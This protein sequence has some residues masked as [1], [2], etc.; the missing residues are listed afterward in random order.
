MKRRLLF[1]SAAAAAAVNGTAII[2][3]DQSRAAV[4]APSPTLRGAVH[5]SRAS[6]KPS[7]GSESTGTGISSLG[8]RQR[9]SSLSLAAGEDRFRRHAGGDGRSLPS[10]REDR[11]FDPRQEEVPFQVTRRRKT[12]SEDGSSSSSSTRGGAGVDEDAECQWDDALDPTKVCAFCFCNFGTGRNCGYWHVRRGCWFGTSWRVLQALKRWTCQSKGYRSSAEPSAL[13]F[14][15]PPFSVHSHMY[16]TQCCRTASGQHPPPLPRFHFLN[17]S[18]ARDGGKSTEPQRTWR[19][20]S[21]RGGDG[22]KRRHHRLR[23]RRTTGRPIGPESSTRP[24]PTT[25]SAG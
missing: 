18:L 15:L 3:A 20:E 21:G 22:E 16:T 5:D 19:G 11:S 24:C 23:A 25:S 8:S 13:W 14:R 12:D 4:T 6:P 1:A 2:A 10:A 9:E 7:G 17:N